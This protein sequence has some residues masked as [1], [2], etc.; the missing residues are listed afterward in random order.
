M[1]G[2]K[3]VSGTG[4]RDGSMGRRPADFLTDHAAT[5]TVPTTDRFQLP[6]ADQ[7]DTRFINGDP[8]TGTWVRS[9][10]YEPPSTTLT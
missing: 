7:G 3:I 5:D 1:I 9:Y 6:A 8:H 4:R 10:A 2:F